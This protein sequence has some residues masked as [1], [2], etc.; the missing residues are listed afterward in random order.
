MKPAVPGKIVNPGGGLEE[1]NG[2]A[3]RR[4]RLADNTPCNPGNFQV[5]E[6]ADQAALDA[7]F[8]KLFQIHI[9]RHE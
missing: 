7:L 2:R 5:V 4:R 6:P 1:N 8:E 9:K 3:G